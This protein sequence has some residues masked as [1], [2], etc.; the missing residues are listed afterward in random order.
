MRLGWARENNLGGRGPQLK[1]RAEGVSTHGSIEG[2]NSQLGERGVAHGSKGRLQLMAHRQKGIGS[3]TGR[4]HDLD[5]GHDL[6]E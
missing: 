3:T 4:C 1:T 6:R 2:R 5:R